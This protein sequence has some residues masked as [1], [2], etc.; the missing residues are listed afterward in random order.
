[1]SIL[2]LSF[3]VSRAKLVFFV[4][5]GLLAGAGH[6][7]VLVL[8]NRSLATLLSGEVHPL[9]RSVLVFGATLLLFAGFTWWLSSRLIAYTQQVNHQ[10]RL[11]IA[12][13][14]LGADH[15][16]VEAGRE[17]ILHSVTKDASVIAHAFVSVIRIATSAIVI[18]ACLA[19]LA[20][21]SWN[22]FLITVLAIVVGG[23]IYALLQKRHLL[24][25]RAARRYE[26]D[27]VDHLKHLLHGI[28]EIKIDPAKGHQI[29]REHIHPA[30]DQQRDN[31]TRGLVGYLGNTLVGQLIFYGLIGTVL[32]APLSPDPARAV[33]F[34]F[35]LLYLLAPIEAILV[36]LPD[37][38]Q[39]EVAA[40]RILELK[41][42]LKRE[43]SP[44]GDDLV[45]LPPF[46][47]LALEDVCFEHPAT[48]DG[49]SFVLGPVSFTLRAGELVF[50]HGGNG[51]GKTTLM[52]LLLGL[53]MPRSG[54]IRVN[55]RRITAEAYSSYRKLFASVLSNY[56]LFD[57]LYGVTEIVPEV[58]DRYLEL[59][60]IAHK[61][62][63]ENG[64][65]TTLELS[66]G[67]RKRVALIA[68]LLE[69]RPLLLLDEWAADQDPLFRKKFY[70]EILPALKRQGLTIIAVTH[71]DRY[72]GIAD[73]L[74]KVEYGQLHEVF[75]TESSTQ[76]VA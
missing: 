17:Q 72:Y 7:G 70:E 5:L 25:L 21:L 45:E 42:G 12:H 40:G 69:K 68:A 4:V 11:D 47:S 57:R 28:Q 31:S 19:Y 58:A 9:S 43:A 26:S 22:A 3:G 8:I 49:T 66:A 44:T 30:S 54:D 13:D 38:Y 2:R 56:Y 75:A 34:V 14:V 1:M 39:A 15:R 36:M 65:F 73:R 24:L 52:K 35:T 51:C 33:G 67:Q 71:D 59:F 64:R 63:L 55:G 32:F 27:F 18:I 61:V 20:Y 10:L 16:Y 53:H 60:E 46:E 37:V 41:A 50:I 76:R 23:S 6:A 48:A 62:K 74:F 29:Y